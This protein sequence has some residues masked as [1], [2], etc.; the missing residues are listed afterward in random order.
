MRAPIPM[1]SL[2]PGRER[3]DAATFPTSP[4]GIGR[5]LKWIMRRCQGSQPLLVVEGIGSYG[6]SICEVAI[7]Q[8]LVVKAPLAYGS[9]R[10][11]GP[12]D[13]TIDAELIGRL[14][15]GWR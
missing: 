12:K 4:Q 14:R 5:A 11:R 13:D 10:H 1:P 15:T 8:G 2:Q 7:S 3:L 6:A 9:P